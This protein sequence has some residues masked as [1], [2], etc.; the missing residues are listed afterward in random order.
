MRVP[1]EHQG[2]FIYECKNPRPYLSRP[3]RT[4]QLEDPKL[5]DGALGAREKPSV[6]VPE[7]FKSRY[8]FRRDEKPPRHRQRLITIS[9]DIRSSKKPAQI[10]GTADAI[11]AKKEK[12]RTER[13]KSRRYTFSL[14][15]RPITESNR[16]HVFA[17]F[18]FQFI[19]LF[20][21]VGLRFKLRL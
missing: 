14:S 15:L 20:L 17:Q 10:A 13:K 3:S 4:K 21:W 7:E 12:E 9:F 19:R 1:L 18:R 6:E 11:L 5:R 16:S 8:D 2:H